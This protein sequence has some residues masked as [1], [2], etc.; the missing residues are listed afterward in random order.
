[1][2]LLDNQGV[3]SSIQCR[4][5]VKSKSPARQ[6]GCLA[7]NVLVADLIANPNHH[8]AV[9]IETKRNTAVCRQRERLF[10]YTPKPSSLKPRLR[11]KSARVSRCR[12][13]IGLAGLS[14]FSLVLREP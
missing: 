3:G 13:L 2:Q 5:D 14:G 11:V 8:Q 12:S 7:V 1:M 4:H 10:L 9:L 6:P